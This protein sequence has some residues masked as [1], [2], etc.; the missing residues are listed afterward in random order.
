[1]TAKRSGPERVKAVEANR[2]PVPRPVI[3]DGVGPIPQAALDV[4]AR[5]LARGLAKAKGSRS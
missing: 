2:R 4:L 5:M 1:M 3:V